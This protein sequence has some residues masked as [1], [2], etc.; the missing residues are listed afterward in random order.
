MNFSLQTRLDIMK[1]ANTMNL[2]YL[3]PP[4]EKTPP[5]AIDTQTTTTTKPNIKKIKEKK[6]KR[7]LKKIIADI[8][9]V[10]TMI[11]NPLYISSKHPPI[12]NLPPNIDTDDSCALFTL[13]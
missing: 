8:P 7:T 10:K 6:T 12:L 9:D 4:H 13:F 5:R 2:Q 3:L 11:F 1:S